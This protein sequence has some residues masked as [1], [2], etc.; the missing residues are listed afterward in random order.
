MTRNDTLT[1]EYRKQLIQRQI[2][3][4]SELLRNQQ[5]QL[6]QLKEQ[7]EGFVLAPEVQQEITTTL[8]NIQQRCTHIQRSKTIKKLSHLYGGPLVLPQPSE[9]FLNLSNFSLTEAQKELLNLGLNCHLQPKFDRVD[10]V[11]ETELLLQSL[12]TLETEGKVLVSP[13]LRPQLLAETTKRRSHKGSSLLSPEL[14]QAAVDLRNNPDITVRRADKSSIYVLLNKEDYLSKL[15]LI[16]SD[17][18]KFK[19]ISSD[20]TSKLKVK[21]NKLIT[22]NNA[23]IDHLHIPPIIGEYSP[24]YI[25]GNVKTHKPDAPLRPIISQVTTPTY[26]L[27]KQINGIITPYIPKKYS[28]RS[29]DE[30]L[31]ILHST[32]PQGI[33]PSLD[34]QSLFS[35]GPILPTINII[36]DNVYH[37]PQLPPPKIPENILKQLLIACTTEAPFKSPTGHLFYQIEGVAMGSPLGCTFAEFYMCNLENSVLQNPD[38]RPHLLSASTPSS[39]N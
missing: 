24:G 30:F 3:Q 5:H 17:T 8:N 33:M 32:N 11:A 19:K 37:H 14:K 18:T 26:R 35:H 38:I 25:Y 23:A 2:N 4:K 9:G 1:V 27:A 39:S 13:D 22:A 12:L 28:L 36:M 16:L 29:I 31:D 21:V 34:V 7:F 10:K 6:N 20:P 15:N